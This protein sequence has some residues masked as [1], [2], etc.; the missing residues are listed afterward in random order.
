LATGE[1]AT[2]LYPAVHFIIVT[3]SRRADMYV[4][5]YFKL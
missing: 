1:H 3:L 4:L 5:L 2:H